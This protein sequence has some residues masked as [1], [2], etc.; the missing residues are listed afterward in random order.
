MLTNEYF[1]DDFSVIIYLPFFLD[2][3]EEEECS[4]LIDSKWLWLN[5]LLVSSKFETS[6][7][8]VIL[9]SVAGIFTSFSK[10]K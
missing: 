7:D 8:I 2:V 9:K 4:R 3:C 10:I 1:L 5:L 6:Y